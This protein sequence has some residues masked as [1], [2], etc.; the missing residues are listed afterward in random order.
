MKEN[1]DEDEEP[2][3]PCEQES[4]NPLKVKC[5]SCKCSW[6]L[7]CCGLEG[8][9]QSPITKIETHGWKCPRC[10]ELPIHIQ[11]PKKTSISQ[12]TINNI[13]SIVNSTV[14]NNLNVLLSAENLNE[15]PTNED[16]APVEEPFT[17]IQSR[18]REKSIQKALV[19]QREE[20]LLIEKKKDNLVI[21][22]MPESDTEDKKEEML[23]DYRK[24]EKIYEGK[25]ELLQEDI[26]HMT[27]I[28][29]KSTNKI[30]PIQI[31]LNP[32][33]RKELLTRNKELKLLENSTSTNI[34][35]STDRTKK[36][37]EADKVLREELK[38]RKRTNPNLVIRNSK[39][40]EAVP[41]H[42][43]A[44]TTTT[45]ASIFN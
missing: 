14:E 28:G 39:I 4:D 2:A 32:N 33:K 35:V 38:R 40:V 12:E 15:E 26:K 10:F 36:Q 3:C 27:R 11:P 18:R 5:G 1:G 21:F 42:Q 20:D 22:G 8:L 17:L 25:V 34:Y 44:Q 37:R 43:R 7:K 30:R 41:F 29:A 45:W 9:T 24:I 19:D 6:H 13:V 16:G 31:T 23:E